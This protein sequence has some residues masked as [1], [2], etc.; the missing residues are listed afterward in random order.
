VYP[1]PISPTA[2]PIKRYLIFLPLS[3]LSYLHLYPMCIQ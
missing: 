1:I 3:S 2:Y